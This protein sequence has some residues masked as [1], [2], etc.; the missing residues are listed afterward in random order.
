MA[1]GRKLPAM[2]R[3]A[4]AAALGCRFKSAKRQ[5]SAA[6]RTVTVKQAPAANCIFKQH[7]VLAQQLHGFHGASGHARIQRGVKLGHQCCGLPILAQQLAARCARR[8]A[9]E[10]VVLFEEVVR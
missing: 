9:R 4:Q 10:A 3:A 5:V 2:K 6:V 8:D 1:V 7:Q